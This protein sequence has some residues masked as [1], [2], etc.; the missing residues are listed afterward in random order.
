MLA[1]KVLEALIYIDVGHT[2]ST[3]RSFQ[4]RV[5][6][7]E[8]RMATWECSCLEKVLG[9]FVLRLRLVCMDIGSL[10]HVGFDGEH[11]VCV[12]RGSLLQI[13]TACS[14]GV[15]PV[16]GRCKPAWTKLASKPGRTSGCGCE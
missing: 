3:C 9:F 16:T 8:R 15:Y 7:P 4:I 2:A 13:S 10:N 5:R 6:V 11:R 14:D 12:P 1:P